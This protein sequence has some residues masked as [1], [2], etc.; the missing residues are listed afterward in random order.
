MIDYGVLVGK[1]E[2]WSRLGGL[3][4]DR[5]IILRLIVKKEDEWL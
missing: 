1:P 5:R 4:L 3:I 2:G